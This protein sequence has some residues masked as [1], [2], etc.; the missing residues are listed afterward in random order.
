MEDIVLSEW[1]KEI[2]IGDDRKNV[3]GSS[4]TQFIRERNRKICG[5]L[6]KRKGD[7][8]RERYS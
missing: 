2:D 1:K 5:F 6:V 3:K 8:L 4:R 7:K